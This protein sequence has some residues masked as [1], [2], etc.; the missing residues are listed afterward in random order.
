MIFF[1]FRIG[2]LEI[3][4]KNDIYDN[5]VVYL[6]IYYCII[7]HILFFTK[8]KDCIVWKTCFEC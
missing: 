3:A 6:Q 5:I 4:R 8:V 2:E 1:S 7:N